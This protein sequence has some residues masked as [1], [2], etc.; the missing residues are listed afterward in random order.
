MRRA[1]V[2]PDAVRVLDTE[3]FVASVRFFSIRHYVTVSWPM[4]H[5][6]VNLILG[7]G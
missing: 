7:L 6:S 4:L 5:L 2:D 1:S 3:H